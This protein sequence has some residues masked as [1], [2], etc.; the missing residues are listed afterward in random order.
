MYCTI[1]SESYF[2]KTLRVKEVGGEG[3][4][5]EGREGKEGRAVDNILGYYKNYLPKLLSPFQIKYFHKDSKGTIPRP[6]P[7]FS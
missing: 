7:H 6:N 3:R 4:E 2:I 1:Y 5:R